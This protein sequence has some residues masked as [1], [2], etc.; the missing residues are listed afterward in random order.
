MH[1][2]KSSREHYTRRKAPEKNERKPPAR[3]GAT[4]RQGLLLSRSSLSA[5]VRSR[6]L[7]LTGTGKKRKKVALRDRQFLSDKRTVERMIGNFFLRRRQRETRV[8]RSVLEHVMNRGWYT[9]ILGTCQRLTVPGE[10][11]SD[12]WAGTAHQSGATHRR[13]FLPPSAMMSS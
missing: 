13:D 12:F 1:Q 11:R 3:Q 5:P 8:T 2:P 10:K 9:S 6:K 7:H 4:G